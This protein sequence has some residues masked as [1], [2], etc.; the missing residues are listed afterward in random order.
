M[1]ALV[2]YHS[3]FGNT[4]AVGQAVAEGLQAAASVKSKNLE[5]LKAEDLKD[6]DLLVMGTPT[7][8]ANVP[9]EVR[10]ILLHLPEGC[11]NGVKVAAFDTSL[12]MNWFMD[13]FN[14]AAPKLAAQ[15]HRLGGTP[16]GEPTSFW[17]SGHEG[18]LADGE[19]QRAK[20]WARS[21]AP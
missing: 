20:A 17:V 10:T 16:V 14:P 5:K 12:K 13:L 4:Q 8:N 21:L 9:A 19:V 3:L 6:I 2:V 15:L 11:L 7:H 18:P 1:N